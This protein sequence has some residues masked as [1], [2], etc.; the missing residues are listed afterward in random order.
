[1]KNEIPD[2]VSIVFFVAFLVSSSLLLFPVVFSSYVGCFG[3]RKAHPNARE[4][5]R[6]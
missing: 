4:E 1:M 3:V 6:P 5:R 2:H